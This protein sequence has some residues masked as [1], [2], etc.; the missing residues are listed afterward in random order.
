MRHTF[1]AL[2]LLIT[3][4]P[5][6][7]QTCAG[8]DLIAALPEAKRAA[9]TAAAE[10]A[11]YPRGNLWRA[12]K[13]GRTATLL[14]TY[15]LDDPRHDAILGAV[16]PMLDSAAVLL[17]EA[18]PAEEK[19]LLSHMAKDPSLILAPAD[20]PTL[21][22]VLPPAEWQALAQAMRDRGV[23]PFMATRFRHWYISMLLAVPPCALSPKMAEGGLDRRL[24]D[25]A[26]AAGIPVRALEP[27]DTAL[28]IFDEMPAEAQVSMIRS[29]LALEDRAEDHMATLTAAYFT[30]DS[31]LIWEF[32]RDVSYGLPGMTPETVDREFAEMEVALMSGR[33]RNWI[34]VIEAAAADGPVFAAFGSLH[35]SGQDGV[36]ALLERGGWALE[37][38]PFPAGAA[39]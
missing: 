21:V 34:P 22:Q 28:R 31:R 15:H 1:A 24:M 19:E 11:P 39:E 26:E 10:A 5:A 27:W 3:G 12:T 29:T 4:S 20:A 30:E 14:G 37:R 36:L 35:L 33:N 16:A 6:L 13:D 17:V 2:A 32:L 18:G 25:R 9:I 7:A 8:E 23:P 38:L